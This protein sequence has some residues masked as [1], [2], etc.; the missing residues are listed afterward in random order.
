MV[1]R[2][3]SVIIPLIRF[4]TMLYNSTASLVCVT[5]PLDKKEKKI[6]GKIYSRTMMHTETKKDM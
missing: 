5:R 6:I 2:F 4:S 1:V 3:G